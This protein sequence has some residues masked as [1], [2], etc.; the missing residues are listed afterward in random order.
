MVNYFQALASLCRAGLVEVWP[1]HHDYQCTSWL[2]IFLIKFGGEGFF[3]RDW[4]H[5]ARGV[6]SV[7]LKC[8][9]TKGT[10]CFDPLHARFGM[11]TPLIS[12]KGLHYQYVS[13]GRARSSEWFLEEFYRYYTHFRDE[14][15]LYIPFNARCY[16]NCKNLIDVECML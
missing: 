15:L 2:E 16:N 13:L 1:L 7:R 14:Q 9:R 5:K 11:K 3:D 12:S 8:G 6:R 10:R 4:K